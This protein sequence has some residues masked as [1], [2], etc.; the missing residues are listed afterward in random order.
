MRSPHRS[1]EFGDCR[2]IGLNP[3]AVDRRL[4][5][6]GDRFSH[7][8]EV[9]RRLIGRTSFLVSWRRTYVGN[10]R[11]Y[12][13]FAVRTTIGSVDLDS[14]SAPGIS[15]TGNNSAVSSSSPACPLL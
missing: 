15:G 14:A 3:P 9:D 5:G 11:A 6:T 1:G 13:C 4:V 12:V 2:Q 10:V 8:A 7:S